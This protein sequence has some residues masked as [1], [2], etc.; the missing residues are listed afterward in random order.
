M[1]IVPNDFDANF[2]SSLFYPDDFRN[3][4]L[5]RINGGECYDWAYYAVR[6]FYHLPLELYSTYAHAYIK[7]EDRFYDSAAPDG[8]FDWRELN[9]NRWWGGDPELQS[10]NEFMDYWNEHGG[11]RKHHW[12]NLLENNLM[13]A[14]GFDYLPRDRQIAA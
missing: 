13:K 5:S 9:T 4:T 2:I 3:D 7:Y 10:L 12:D 1:L 11:G 14:L 6:T 8:V